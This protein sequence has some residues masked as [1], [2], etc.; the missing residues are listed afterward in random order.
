MRQQS[1]VPG[2]QLGSVA[3][4]YRSSWVCSERE[5]KRHSSRPAAAYPAADRA[6]AEQT[7]LDRRMQRL[8]AVLLLAREAI[9]TRKLGRYANLAD[10]TEARTLAGRL[11]RLYDQHGC[12]FHIQ[13]VA[14]GLQLM[15]RSRFSPW[16][17][18]MAGIPPEFRLSAPAMETL[19]VVAYRQPVLRAEIEAIRGVGCGEVLRQLMERDLVRIR[20]RSEE[21][22]RPYL[23]STTRR[24]LQLFGLRTL[25]ELPRAEAMRYAESSTSHGE[26][27]EESAVTIAIATAEPQEPWED[28]T[29][30]ATVDDSITDVVLEEDEFEEDEDDLDDDEDD[31]ELDDDELD[32]DELDDDELDDD[33]L[34]D[35]ELDDDEDDEDEDDDED[36]WEE[37]DDE[38][39]DEVDGE[40]ADDDDEEDGDEEWGEEDDDAEEDDDE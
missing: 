13:E 3:A 11:N 16:I 19:A 14:G 9:S 18:R 35:D 30:V 31:D 7:L 5:M 36:E 28:A 26:N 40:E 21:L 15:T 6:R 32:D 4:R 10:G 39:D 27:G 1:N 38:D 2:C 17:R 25:D 20:G 23:Y 37:V 29:A 34:D 22:G 8:E 12:A 24:F 33:E